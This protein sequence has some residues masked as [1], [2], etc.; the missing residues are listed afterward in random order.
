[1]RSHDDEEPTSNEHILALK[2]RLNI[3]PIRSDLSDFD[4]RNPKTSKRK[5]KTSGEETFE[6][7]MAA[8]ERNDVMMCLSMLK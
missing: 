8:V 2:K 4:T 3:R 1:M 6:Q 7:F 5:A